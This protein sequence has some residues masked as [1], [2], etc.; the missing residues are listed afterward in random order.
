MT[1]DDRSINKNSNG[2]QGNTVAH[3]DFDKA[4]QEGFRFQH[5]LPYRELETIE[6][7]TTSI[8]EVILPSGQVVACDPLMDLD[9]EDKFMTQVAPGHYPVILSLAGFPATGERRIAC[10]K[11]QITQKK[12]IRWEV[13]TIYPDRPADYQAYGVD[14]GTGSFLDLE[15]ARVIKQLAESDSVAYQNAYKEGKEAELKFIN[16]AGRRFEEEHCDLVIAQMEAN[17]QQHRDDAYPYDRKG[18][19]ANLT[20]DNRTSAN[21]ITFSTGWGDGGYASYWGYDAT[22]DIACL[23]TDFAL[24]Y[25]EEANR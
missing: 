14:S 20:I 6:I 4:F 9:L 3:T 5:K 13:A 10:A 1:I 11:L 2:S 19:W 24:F 8:G 25:E 17:R 18:D 23:V 21:V 16:E 15:A 22:G 7:S 12:P